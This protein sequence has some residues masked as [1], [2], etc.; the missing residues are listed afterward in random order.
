[1]SSPNFYVKH[2]SPSS[3]PCAVHRPPHQKGRRKSASKCKSV[4][5]ASIKTLCN[6]V[7][8]A[9]E[10]MQNMPSELTQNGGEIK[11]K[12]M[13][14]RARACLRHHLAAKRCQ[15]ATRMRPRGMQEGPEAA[16]EWPGGGQERCGRNPNPSKT[17]PGEIS[18]RNHLIL[19]AV[20]V[21]KACAERLKRDF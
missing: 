5:T 2:Q 13:R 11:P 17:E 6:E 21:A 8:G 18:K 20:F 15:S 1:M 7:R 14:N 9:E 19:M 4:V 3:I 12:S 16:P 10:S